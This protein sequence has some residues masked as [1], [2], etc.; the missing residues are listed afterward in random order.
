MAANDIAGKEERRIGDGYGDSDSGINGN[1]TQN[2]N[3]QRV[4]AVIR[5]WNDW[6]VIR[7]RQIR[8]RI[9]AQQQE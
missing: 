3:S 8:E 2:I 6:L 5:R 4:T 7:Q 9:Q 1:C